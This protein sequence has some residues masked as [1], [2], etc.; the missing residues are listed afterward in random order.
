MCI[1]PGDTQLAMRH[2]KELNKLLRGVI[3][4]QGEVLSNIQA[5]L[6]PKKIVT[7]ARKSNQDI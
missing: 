2:D 1:I 7:K 3:I 5:A 4:A 6:L